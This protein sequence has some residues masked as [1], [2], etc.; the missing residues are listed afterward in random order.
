[1]PKTIKNSPKIAKKK[2]FEEKTFWLKTKIFGP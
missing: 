1:M 2:I